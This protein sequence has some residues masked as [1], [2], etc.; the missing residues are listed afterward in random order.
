MSGFGCGTGGET[1]GDVSLELVNRGLE[2]ADVDDCDGD[3][4]FGACDVNDGDENMVMIR[5]VCDGDNDGFVDTPCTLFVAETAEG[6][7]TQN[8]REE[9]G[10]NC[11]VCP[12]IFNPEQ[13]DADEDGVGD[14]CVMES[15]VTLSDL[16]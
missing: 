9:V 1:V 2:C 7:F 5:S 3:G 6:L 13:I 10:I 4:V 8:D 15:N 12:D 11:D 16:P 14:D